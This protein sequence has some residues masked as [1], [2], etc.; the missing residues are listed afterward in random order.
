[1]RS[2]RFF[3]ISALAILKAQA[4]PVDSDRNPIVQTSYGQLQGNISEYR[5]DIYTFKGIPFASRPVG[6]ARWT[7][8]DKA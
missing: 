2:L 3:F 8:P 5:D 6:E 1:M 7:P 4:A